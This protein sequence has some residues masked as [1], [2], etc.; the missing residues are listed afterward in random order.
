MENSPGQHS[1]C[2]EHLS[3]TALADISNSTGNVPPTLSSTSSTGSRLQIS[4]EDQNDFFD[5]AFR[6]PTKKQNTS[7]RTRR[8]VLSRAPVVASS[9]EYKKY[10]EKLEAERLTKEKNQADKKAMRLAKK[11][12]KT[13][14]RLPR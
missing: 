12:D 11:V 14:K 13:T 3:S 6:I 10:Y 9:N 4:T 5:K 1:M 2:T 8:T 7:R